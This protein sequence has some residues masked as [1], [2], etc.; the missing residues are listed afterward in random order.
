VNQ[1]AK[2]GQQGLTS[3]QFTTQNGQTMTKYTPGETYQFVIQL[4]QPAK[5]FMMM[6]AGELTGYGSEEPSCGGMKLAY[7][8]NFQVLSGSWKAPEYAIPL[9]LS[10]AYETPDGQISVAG[11][12]MEAMQPGMYGGIVASQPQQWE[13]PA[14]VG[15]YS[16]KDWVVAA[17]M[18][19]WNEYVE[20]SVYSWDVPAPQWEQPTWEQPAWEPVPEW[21]APAANPWEDFYAPAP[22]VD[23]YGMPAMEFGMTE[24]YAPPQVQMPEF[25]PQAEFSAVQTGFDAF[26]ATAPA[27][28]V[29][30]FETFYAPAPA[31]EFYGMPA[32][33]IYAQPMA[34]DNFGQW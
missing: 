26:Y 32:V 10:I 33:D 2:E 15:I 31:V 14:T 3:V 34:F 21:S 24:F 11:V 25:F 28:E 8:N 17:P 1:V 16:T 20:P 22:A 23:F 5:S 6:S 7:N 4:G 12:S 18:D 13:Q 30:G 29:T 9:T 27:V 19:T